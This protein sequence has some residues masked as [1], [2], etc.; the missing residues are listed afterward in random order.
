MKRLLAAGSGDIF[1]I[2]HV[3]RARER[4][5][6]HNPEFT[7]IEWYRV[8]FG[9]EQLMDELAALIAVLL[10]T[11][12]GRRAVERLS[13]R[14]AFRRELGID[15]LDVETAQLERAAHERGL[16]SAR[17]MRTAPARRDAMSCS[18]S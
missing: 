18:N 12:G 5:R 3:V 1:Q 8:G 10:G 11:R 2:C 9:M 7:L 13:Y 6:L 4:S 17:P 16:T 14:E 15:P